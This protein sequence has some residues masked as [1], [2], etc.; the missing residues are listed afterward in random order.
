MSA[1][2]SFHTILQRAVPG[3][4]QRERVR[5]HRDSIVTRL[6]SQFQFYKL[7]TIGSFSR[8]T[9][10]AG[11]SDVDLFSVF[12]KDEVTWGNSLKSSTTMLDNVRAALEG[13][14]PNTT[15][16]RDIHAIVVS[17]SS[18]VQV[19][20]VPA[21]FAGMTADGRHATYGMPD[22]TGGWMRVSPDAHAA[23]IARADER[24]SGKLR[25]TA[26]ILKYWRA[27]RA[28]A[29]P[30]SSFH[31]EML[32]AQEDVCAGV[33]TYAD[34]FTELLMKLA[35]RECAALRDPLGIA[36]NISAVK[37][38]SAQ[39]RTV[40]SV[41]NSRDHAKFAQA[42]DVWGGTSEARRKWNIVFNGHFP[43]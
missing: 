9:D 32:L 14:F 2:D 24:A 43:N 18:G 8:Q 23:Y 11:E 17:Y 31:I 1:A 38:P 22:G 39:Q 26:R 6:K 25:G 34:C 41:R 29:I 10:M 12:T 16:K 20:V 21:Y 7:L 37:T 4:L 5:T 36:G 19:D 30:L 15:I 35:A 3:E 27:C 13:R 42:S 28:P 33:K 40:D